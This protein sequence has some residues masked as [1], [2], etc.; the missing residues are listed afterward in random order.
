[1]KNLSEEV[2][3]E[4]SEYYDLDVYNIHILEDA[5]PTNHLLCKRGKYCDFYGTTSHIHVF[6]K[7]DYIY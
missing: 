2:K 3:K 4:L 7:D 5:P 1:M 6:P